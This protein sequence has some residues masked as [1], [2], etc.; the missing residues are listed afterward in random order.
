MSDLLK[1]RSEPMNVSASN[2]ETVALEFTRLIRKEVGMENFR[3]IRRLNA[4]PDY[5]YGSCCASHEFCD[6][7]MLMLEAFQN[8][9]FE[10]D[11]SN[12]QHVALWN[13]AWDVA[14]RLYL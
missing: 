2:P 3:Q 14:R 9:G 11:L 5:N 13:D 1:L 7:N 10:P 4:T 8:L 12:D 6:A